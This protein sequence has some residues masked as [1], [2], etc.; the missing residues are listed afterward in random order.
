MH[1]SVRPLPPTQKFLRPNVVEDDEIAFRRKRPS[2]VERGEVYIN[3]KKYFYKTFF[4]PLA[5]GLMAVAVVLSP[6]GADFPAC[7]GEGSH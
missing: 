4:S 1:V 5:Y 2:S 3:I 6:I 7:T